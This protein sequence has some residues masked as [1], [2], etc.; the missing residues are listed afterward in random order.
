MTK[1]ELLEV[2]TS[3]LPV[4]NDYEVLEISKVLL[5][6]INRATLEGELVISE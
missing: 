6:V 4:M 3:T 5:N 2:F 1:R